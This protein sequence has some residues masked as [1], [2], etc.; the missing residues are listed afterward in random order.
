[1]QQ[2]EVY[3]HCSCVGIDDLEHH[4]SCLMVFVMVIMVYC[5]V[6]LLPYVDLKSYYS[7]KLILG[8]IMMYC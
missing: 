7:I 2:K 5:V 8:S 3:E 1:M 6:L 4:S